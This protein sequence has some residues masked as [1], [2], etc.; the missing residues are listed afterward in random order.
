MHISFEAPLDR[1]NS[2]SIKHLPGALSQEGNKITTHS[3]KR[4]SKHHIPNHPS[5]KKLLAT[6]CLTNQG[7][8]REYIRQ[9]HIK[10]QTHTIITAIKGLLRIDL[11]TC[12]TDK[13]ITTLMQDSTYKTNT[14][15]RLLLQIGEI[16][17]KR[18]ES[19][20]LKKKGHKTDLHGPSQ[21]TDKTNVNSTKDIT[22]YLN[23]FLEAA[24]N[25]VT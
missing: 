23:Q 4:S 9:S 6:A 25:K 1:I 8:I 17:T 3:Y 20:H 11:K 16:E 14:F 21:I 18:N 12:R 13:E 22:E 10:N 24:R 19:L 5:P 7:Y 2:E 15:L